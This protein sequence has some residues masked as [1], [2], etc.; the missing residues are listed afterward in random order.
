MNYDDLESYTLQ[1]QKNNVTYNISANVTKVSDIDYSKEDL[2]KKVEV[3]VSYMI[4]GKQK[5]VVINT[6]KGKVL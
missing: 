5:E 2:V 4:D 6:L 1:R 3:K